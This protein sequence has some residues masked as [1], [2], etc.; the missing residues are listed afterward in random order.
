MRRT[1]PIVA[2]LTCICSPAM[3]GR[4]ANGAMVV[5]TNNSVNYTTTA[6]YCDACFPLPT[7]CEELN[8][9][10]NKA[11]GRIRWSGLLRRSGRRRTRR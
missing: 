7:T 2:I 5:H 10:S 8:P 4:N 3:A 11:P 6:N 1:L 9:T